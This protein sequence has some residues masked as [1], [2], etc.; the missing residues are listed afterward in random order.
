MARQP[1]NLHVTLP[2]EK[3]KNKTGAG[4]VPKEFNS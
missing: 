3:T 2:N 4:E 1:V